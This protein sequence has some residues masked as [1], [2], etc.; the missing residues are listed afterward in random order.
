MDEMI[1]EMKDGILCVGWNYGYTDPSEGNF[2]FKMAKGYLIENGEKTKIV[3]DA[4]I[5]GLTLDVLNR[6]RLIDKH[7]ELD[8]GH[9]GKGG[10]TVRVGS[11]GG[12]TL[13]DNM[14][15]GGQ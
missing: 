8:Q 6:I 13:I 12:Y 11:G 1:E 14:I 4:A 9:C 10:Q 7:I 2:M 15:I 3:R 5:S